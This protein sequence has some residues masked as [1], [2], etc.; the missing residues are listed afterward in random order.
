MNLEIEDGIKKSG[1]GNNHL[2]GFLE[3]PIIT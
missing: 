2:A 3:N 1:E